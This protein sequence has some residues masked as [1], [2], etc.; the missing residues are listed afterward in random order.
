MGRLLLNRLLARWNA[1]ARIRAQRP[2][3]EKDVGLRL[4]YLI[5]H[6][7]KALLNTKST[8]HFL[9]K[10]ARRVGQQLCDVLR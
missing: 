4:V 6:P 9:L 3:E 7:T 8:P 2:T 1:G 10:K 5:V